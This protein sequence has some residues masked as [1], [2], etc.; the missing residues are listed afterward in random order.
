M[1]LVASD[2]EFIKVDGFVII[3]SNVNE[4]D[5]FLNKIS[6]TN[7]NNFINKPKEE[8]LFK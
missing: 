4:I 5:N 3:F 2:N 7:I 8:D 6:L 1:K